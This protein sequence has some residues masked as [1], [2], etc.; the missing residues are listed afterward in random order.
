M[1]GSF[2]LV[3]G[4]VGGGLRG[5]GLEGL[6]RCDRGMEKMR[7]P[8]G[9]VEVGRGEAGTSPEGRGRIDF[10][11]SYG[12]GRYRMTKPDT[13]AR[14][15]SRGDPLVPATEDLETH[16]KSRRLTNKAYYRKGGHDGQY[17]GGGFRIVCFSGPLEVA[18]IPFLSD[19][20][21]TLCRM[22]SPEH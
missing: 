12:V 2:G 19:V 5:E 14:R 15:A 16:C 3:C 9:M 8:S 17:S 7:G 10:V 6:V 21:S 11:W 1:R 4:L 20:R 13:L 18:E 22:A